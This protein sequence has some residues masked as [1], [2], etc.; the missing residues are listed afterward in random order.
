[1]RGQPKWWRRRGRKPRQQITCWCGRY[2]FP[3]R[4]GG[5]ACSGADWA[6]SY[7][8]RDH[9]CCGNCT[10]NGDN[11]RCDVARGAERIRYCD[12]MRDNLRAGDPTR[13]PLVIEGDWR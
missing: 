8:E 10:S 11:R 5:G 4:I 7:F 12:G 6:Q 2:E 9:S 1:M 3:H 13:H